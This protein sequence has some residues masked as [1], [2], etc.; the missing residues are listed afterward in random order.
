M[1]EHFLHLQKKSLHLILIF[2]VNPTRKMVSLCL[3]FSV[4]LQTRNENN[5]F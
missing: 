2:I 3:L 1:T 4:I 5:Y